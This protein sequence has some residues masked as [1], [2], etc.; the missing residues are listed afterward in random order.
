MEP[1]WGPE[2]LSCNILQDSTR[3]IR[4]IFMAMWEHHVVATMTRKGVGDFLIDFKL[5]SSVFSGRSE[6]EQQ[7]LKLNVVGGFQTQQQKALW[8]SDITPAC[9]LCGEPDTR[10]HRFLLCS[11]LTNVRQ[12]HGEACRVLQCLRPEWCYLPLP[13]LFDE[14]TIIRA[15]VARIKLPDLDAL[16]LKREVHTC[17]FLQ[18]VVQ[19]IHR[20]IS[21]GWQRGQF[22]R[23][24]QHL[25]CDRRACVGLLV[26][27]A[28]AASTLSSCCNGACGR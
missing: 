8:D 21:V 6:C 5:L 13:R 14:V 7:L 2:L 9:Q 12:Q 15:F 19:Y 17:V 20:S 11:Y 26:F 24:C 27:A 28:T 18:M 25:N 22:F 16:P 4:L 23:I 3:K 1:F 10:E